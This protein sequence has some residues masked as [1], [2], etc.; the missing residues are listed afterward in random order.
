MYFR[1]ILFAFGFCIL[2]SCKYTSPEFRRL[3]T[4]KVNN[5]S[6]SEVV[7]TNDAIFFNPNNY[8]RVHL[9]K[10]NLD[11]YANNKKIG[12]VENI[13]NSKVNINASSEF[14]IPFSVTL[15]TLNLI[16]E[17]GSMIDIIMG[18]SIDIQIK[19]Q[20]VAKSFIFKKQ[21]PIEFNKPI[22]LKDIKK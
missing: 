11:I 1:L 10:L 9:K 17:L 18:K 14:S 15:K 3:E 8:G 22:S 5:V 13:D 19:G 7:L 4:W 12:Y 6:A 16:G 2:I 21:I 20:L